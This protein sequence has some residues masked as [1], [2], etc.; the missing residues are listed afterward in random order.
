MPLLKIAFALFHPYLNS[1]LN[2]TI[3]IVLQVGHH[4]L[5]II[6]HR[7]RKEGIL[8]KRDPPS[9]DLDQGA[10]DCS[11]GAISNLAQDFSQPTAT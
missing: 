10:P 9:H 1:V 7:K 2:P 3:D 4:V 5:T 8:C 6:A 11:L